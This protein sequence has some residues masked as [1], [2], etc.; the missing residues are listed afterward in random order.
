MKVVTAVMRVTAVKA[1]TAIPG[2]T[3]VKAVTAAMAKMGMREDT[4]ASMMIT[5]GEAAAILTGRG[6]GR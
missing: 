5:E 3:A 4:A 6:K 2:V 1:V